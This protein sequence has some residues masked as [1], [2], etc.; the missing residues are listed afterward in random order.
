MKRTRKIEGF[1][2]EFCSVSVEM[3]IDTPYQFWYFSNS[4]EAA[5]ELVDLVIA[6]TKRATAS[7]VEVNRH[8]PDVTPY[9]GGYSIVTDFDGNPKCVVRTDEIRDIPFRDVDE[10]F[11]FDEGEG[12]RTLEFWREVHHSY[13]TREAAE[14]GVP[15]NDDSLICCER[16]SLL[17][18]R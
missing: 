9:V 1:W 7:L 8:M 14:F 12:D 2:R 6:G 13:F 4:R 11:A 17:Y 5:L 3:P 16:F 18:P 15:F 10:K